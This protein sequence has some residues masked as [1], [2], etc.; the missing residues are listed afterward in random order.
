MKPT[1][2]AAELITQLRCA[3]RVRDQEEIHMHL[4]QKDCELAADEI[5]RLRDA[6]QRIAR[7]KYDGLDHHED[8]RRLERA[9][10]IAKRAVA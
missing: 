7:A 6:L 8:V 3:S 2:D 4:S 9:I 10:E 1:P 5:E